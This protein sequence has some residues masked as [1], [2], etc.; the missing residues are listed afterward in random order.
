[1]N[2]FIEISERLIESVP[3]KYIREQIQWLEQPDRLIG[4]KGARG[5]GKSTLMLQFAKI[6]LKGKKRLYISLDDISFADR[7]LPDFTDDFVKQGGDY[8]LIDEVHHYKNWPQ[9]IKNIYDRYPELKIIFTGSS[10]LHLNKGT[11]VL[12]R[13]AVIHSLPGLSLREYIFLARG[14]LFEK[15][16]FTEILENHSE[17]GKRIWSRIKPIELFNEYL[18]VGY[19]P[20]FLE[21]PLSYDFRLRESIIKVLESD[22]P[23]VTNIEYFNIDKIKQLLHIISQSVPF[24]PNIDKLSER[25]GIGKNTLKA[26]LKYLNEASIINALYS[27]RKGITL[28]TKPEKIYLHHPNLMYSLASDLS[29]KG[30]LRESFFLNQV[31]HLYPVL[32]PEEGDFLVNNKWL[33]EIGGKNKGKYQIKNHTN[34][35]LALDNIETGFGNTIPLWLFGFLY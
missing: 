25:I 23:Y 17:I 11:S 14:V 26:Y 9:E 35:W 6:H 20:Y 29:D 22:I 21:N 3:D 16:S 24:K 32:Y 1:M 4:I 2:N 33:F 8:L 30:S 27:S 13:R 19:Y 15:L 10:M 7:T 18:R 12:S 28:L 5:T 34:G 31:Q